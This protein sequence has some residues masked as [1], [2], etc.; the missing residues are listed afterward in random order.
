MTAHK[1]GT[2]HKARGPAP[3]GAGPVFLEVLLYGRAGPRARVTALECAS[4]VFAHAA[5]DTGVLARLESPGEAFGGDR[6]TV[7]DNLGIGDLRES[8]TAVAY[9]K[10]NS[11]SSSRQIALWRQSILLLLNWVR[12]APFCLGEFICA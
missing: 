11:G 2:V 12:N 7:A 1:S 3:C 4:L 9:G 8:R 5:P 6:A 10:N